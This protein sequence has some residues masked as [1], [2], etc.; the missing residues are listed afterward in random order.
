VAWFRRLPNASTKA[1]SQPFFILS[2]ALLLIGL[3][4]LL[5]TSYFLQAAG[6]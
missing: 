6:D 1:P 4:P 5:L 2:S 3:V